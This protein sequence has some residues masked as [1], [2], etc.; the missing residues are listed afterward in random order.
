MMKS[1]AVRN[2]FRESRVQSRVG[3]LQFGEECV[4]L[5]GVDDHLG[6]GVACGVVRQEDAQLAR[7]L[8][9]PVLCS[10]KYSH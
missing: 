6:R 7:E 4:G 10:R 9:T 5:R 3:A 8:L 2:H 1:H